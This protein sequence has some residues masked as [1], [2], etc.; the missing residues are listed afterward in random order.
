MA[1]SSIVERFKRSFRYSLVRAYEQ[2][3]STDSD[4]HGECAEIS[5][6]S[7][8]EALHHNIIMLFG[9]TP[10]PSVQQISPSFSI[11]NHLSA[12]G[13]ILNGH[14]LDLSL[15]GHDKQA[16]N[17][18]SPYMLPSTP[19]T[20]M[21]PYK[22]TT[23]PPS[24]APQNASPNYY[25]ARGA[26]RMPNVSSTSTLSNEICYPGAWNNCGL[27]SDEQESSRALGYSSQ[28]RG[29]TS[30][31]HHR[32]AS[33]LPH[34]RFP[35]TPQAQSIKEMPSYSSSHP[36]PRRYS[37]VNHSFDPH[38]TFTASFGLPGTAL[39]GG[40][41]ISP[42]HS[43]GQNNTQLQGSSCTGQN[44]STQHQQNSTCVPR[45]FDPMGW[46]HTHLPTTADVHGNYFGSHTND[47]A[48]DS[49]AE[50]FWQNA[51]VPTHA[52][53]SATRTSRP[54]RSNSSLCAYGSNLPLMIQGNLHQ[55]GHYPL[56]ISNVSG[57]NAVAHMSEI[58]SSSS[59]SPSLNMPPSNNEQDQP[60]H[61]IRVTLTTTASPQTVG[62]PSETSLHVSPTPFAFVFDAGVQS[63][64]SFQRP[65]VPRN[66][67]M[68]HRAVQKGN[69]VL[70]SDAS[71][72]ATASPEFRPEDIYRG[73]AVT[74]DTTYT[75]AYLK[76]KEQN[77]MKDSI[78]KAKTLHNEP[79]KEASKEEA[80]CLRILQRQQQHAER[81]KRIRGTQI[82][83]VQQQ[84]LQLRQQNG[85]Q[86][87]SGPQSVASSPYSDHD[88]VKQRMR[89]LQPTILVG[90]K[91]NHGAIDPHRHQ[92][93]SAPLHNSLAG[94]KPENMS[95]VNRRSTDGDPT[96]LGETLYQANVLLESQGIKYSIGCQ[97]DR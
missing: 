64:N 8:T 36:S 91:R 11:N 56:P 42:N 73:P 65:N 43:A 62:Q 26:D 53:Q 51:K 32:G 20:L 55:L 76:H 67:N 93:Q 74:E 96:S 40:H 21:L 52:A 46:E 71:R 24:M 58:T 35:S 47:A 28:G 57:M 17:S 49:P 9:E 44:I 45:N 75:S 41:G 72:N 34:P 66:L 15:G 14:G 30:S 1:Y 85:S 97:Y 84:Q 78:Q 54:F 10:K 37:G 79:A 95:R 70:M 25:Q 63:N 12:A 2:S 48:N 27:P 87:A 88:L 68:P 19:Q 23:M 69:L 82:H 6:P 86:A 3:P 61:G 13:S 77:A 18:H 60:D 29:P 90:T 89:G 5:E 81:I 31:L 39:V 83:S 94:A 80:H 50:Y 92:R 7:D 4:V 38:N 33:I 59:S 22:H 16:E